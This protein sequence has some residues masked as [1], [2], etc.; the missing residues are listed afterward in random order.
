MKV[1]NFSLAS[2]TGEDFI[3]RDQK[4]RLVLY[5]YPKDNTSGCTREGEDFS[6]LHSKFVKCQTAIFGISRDSIASHE[7]F[8][9][10][11]KFK[12][13]LLSDSD[14]V[15]CKLFDVIKLKNMYGKKVLGIER[16]TFVIDTDGTILKEWRKV[17]VDGHANEVLDFIESLN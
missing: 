6:K 10:K 11:M 15:A 12:F 1:K 7:K 16:S 5:F 9:T 13:H 2:T 4:Q 14:E 17:K 3:L 8:R